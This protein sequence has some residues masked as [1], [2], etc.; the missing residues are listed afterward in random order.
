MT[1]RGEQRPPEARSAAAAAGPPAAEGLTFSEAARP[2]IGSAGSPE[3]PVGPADDATEVF[4]ER[5]LKGARELRAH[6]GV[7]EDMYRRTAGQA[8]ADARGFVLYGALDEV[9]KTCM[10]LIKLRELLSDGE[11]SASTDTISRNI[12]ALTLEEIGGRERRLLE[13]LVM[14]VLFTM[15]NEQ[16]Y[17]RHLLMLELLEDELR[18]NEDL[19]EFHGARSLNV[20]ASIKSQVEWIV[21]HQAEIDF[22]RAWYLDDKSRPLPTGDVPA[23]RQLLNQH[24]RFSSMRARMRRALPLMRDGEKLCIGLTYAASYGQASETLHFSADAKAYRLRD[25]AERSGMA[26]LGLLTFC[27]LLRCHELLGRP[28][29]PVVGQ[30]AKVYEQNTEAA[31]LVAQLSRRGFEVG[32]FVLAYG[33]LAE[34][35]EVR[36]SP[37]GYR[38]Y[39]VRYL[40]ERPMPDVVED[41][42]PAQYVQRLYTRV[43]AVEKMRELLPK[44][45]IPREQVERLIQSAPEVLQEGLRESL[46]RLW[47]LGLRDAIRRGGV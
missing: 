24:V 26:K 19:E 43:M 32:D 34:I 15:S 3:T 40:A 5:G 7:G 13:V 30:L 39:R 42:F 38:S 17:Y 25:G 37:Y 9:E 28:E 18:Q 21:Q 41:W 12:V 22:T 44:H 31:R 10:L 29:T 27:V 46:R 11:I 16:P 23:A 4:I 14:L 33:D 8:V 1:D 45:G 6:L 36:E 20:E 2:E 35:L 47:G